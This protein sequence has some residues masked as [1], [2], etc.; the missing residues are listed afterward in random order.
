MTKSPLIL[1]YQI[2]KYDLRSK[3]HKTGI[4]TDIDTNIDIDI[5]RNT[6]TRAQL[7]SDMQI[8]RRKK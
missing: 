5:D 4:D 2:T 6:L 3:D 1:F 8:Y 7:H